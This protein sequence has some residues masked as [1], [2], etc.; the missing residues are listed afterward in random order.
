MVPSAAQIA[1]TNT[2]VSTDEDLAGPRIRTIASYRIWRWIAMRLPL[3]ANTAHRGAPATPDLTSLPT[4]ASGI[5]R[6]GQ[7]GHAATAG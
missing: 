4:A 2:T 5:G 6:T 3:P 7:L 1:I